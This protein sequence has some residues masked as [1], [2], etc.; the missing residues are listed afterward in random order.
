MGHV[1]LFWALIVRAFFLTGR[2]SSL[3][4]RSFVCSKDIQ[5]SNLLGGFFV[6]WLG[7]VGAEYVF[8]VAVVVFLGGLYRIALQPTPGHS[9]PL[10]PTPGHSDQLQPTPGHSDQ[11]RPL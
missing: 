11:L 1:Q 3:Y 9:N 6:G 8:G 5:G 2:G 10:Q 7:M 4:P